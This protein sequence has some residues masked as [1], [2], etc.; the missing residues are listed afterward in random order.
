MRDFCPAP[1]N[2]RVD[3]T[4]IDDALPEIRA[5]RGCP[6]NPRYHAEGDVWIHTR[7]VCEALAALPGFRALP[8]EDREMVFSAAVLHD[9]GKPACTRHQRDGRIT[10]HGHARRGALMA[11]ALLWRAGTPFDVR[12][13]I[14]DLVRRHA[15]PLWATERDDGTRSVVLASQTVRCDL[16]AL[17]AEADVGGRRADDLP[18]LF[19]RVELFVELCREQRSWRQPRAFASPHARFLYARGKWPHVDFRPHEDFRSDVVLMSGLPGAGKDHWI[20]RHLAGRPA[21]SL[22]A[23]REQLGID[24]AGNQGR[25]IQEARRQAREHL[26]DGAPFVW[27]ATNVSRRIRDACVELFAGYDARIRIVYVEASPERLRSQNRD[28]DDPVP[29]R[30]LERLLGRWEVP[31]PFEGHRVEYWIDGRRIESQILVKTAG[32]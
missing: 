30:V 12:E 29:D 7:L 26:R 21:V 2:W 18:S 17:L 8:E 24:A 19:E 22:D 10:S 32:R 31:A 1:P 15:L 9:I 5:L 25:V 3:W 28:R 23:I 6:Q 16:L 20:R 11:H 4:A 14:V 27:N 13:Q